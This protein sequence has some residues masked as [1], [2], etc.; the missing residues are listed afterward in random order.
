MEAVMRILR[1]LKSK[2]D[3]GVFYKKNGH[4]ELIAYIDADWAGDRDSRRSIFGYFTLVGG[5][6]VT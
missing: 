6:L 1:Y 3:K 5:N 2:S 4:L